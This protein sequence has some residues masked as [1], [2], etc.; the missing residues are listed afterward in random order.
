MVPS[1]HAIVTQQ[2]VNDRDIDPEDFSGY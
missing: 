1:L 2:S